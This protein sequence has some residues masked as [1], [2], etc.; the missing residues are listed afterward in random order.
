MKI[1]RRVTEP[2]NKLNKTAVVLLCV[3]LSLAASSCS[4][5]SSDS[6]K[7]VSPAE[8]LLVSASEE[9]MTRV[10]KLHD[11]SLAQNP[12]IFNVSLNES[13]SKN[14][15]ES[16]FQSSGDFPAAFDQRK[17]GIVTSVKLQNPW[18]N[19]WAFG[20]AA[21]AETSAISA[22]KAEGGDIGAS[23]SDISERHLSWFA[24]TP[25]EKGSQ[26]G[27]GLNSSYLL[28]NGGSHA[29]S[30]IRMDSGGMPSFTAAL[31]AAGIG[32]VSEKSWPYRSRQGYRTKN[33]K[34]G[35]RYYARDG[36]WTIPE[37][38]RYKAVRTLKNANF[39]PSP[40]LYE[41]GEYSYNKSAEAAIKKELM[42]GRG[43][44]ICFHADQYLAGQGESSDHM[45][46]KTWAQYTYDESLPNHTSQIVGWDD[47]YSRSN[48]LKGRSK[49][50]QDMT[51]PADGAWIVKNS[52]G[53]RS[54]K[55][56][57]KNDWGIDGTGYFYIS[58]YDK[59]LT[60]AES[61]DFY[62]KTE[63]KNRENELCYQYD[64]MPPN[65]VLVL[66]SKHKIMAANTFKAEKAGPI[67]ALTIETPGAGTKVSYKIYKGKPG[68]SGA[69]LAGRL[70]ASGTAEPE[71]GGYHR[72]ELDGAS[73]ALKKGEYFTVVVA[74]KQGDHYLI[75]VNEN[76]SLKAFKKF[77]SDDS[78]GIRGYAKSVI[79]NGESYIYSEIPVGSEEERASGLWLDWAELTASASE[80]LEGMPVY[81]NF[82][83]KAFS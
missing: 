20:T 51:P 38:A 29:P 34:M 39:L 33:R 74:E 79:G 21:A 14:P 65:S 12:N 69:K 16:T 78:Q 28:G 66:K 43:V 64:L 41:D 76:Y 35:T 26:G 73:K 32:P 36:D 80:R 18:D 59:S 81:D 52:W 53:S 4:G 60:F 15:S 2:H 5:S 68:G 3:F 57:N 71:Y 13:T 46:G 23:A 27:E 77:S 50:G 17:L 72:I 6:G 56:P 47:H 11:S 70:L 19:C 1:I 22:D 45:N 9:E 61:Y 58:Y 49:A 62:G 67:R 54:G 8:D 48:F 83:I 10:N 42:A 7:A 75:P 31:F 63:S 55:F 37:S 44:E 82:T 30:G 25:I 24:Y 40:A